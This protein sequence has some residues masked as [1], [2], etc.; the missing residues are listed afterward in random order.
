MSKFLNPTFYFNLYNEQISGQINELPFAIKQ[1]TFQGIFINKMKL[2]NS[3]GID[4]GAW[5]TSKSIV[6]T[7]IR[8]PYGRISAAVQKKLMDN[9]LQV[10]FSVNDIFRWNR[11]VATSQFQNIDIFLDNRWETLK[12]RL[13]FNYKFSQGS[14]KN[15]KSRASGIETEQSRVKLED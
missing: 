15:K 10:R 1:G 2:P 13:S 7:F 3:W 12:F 6:S 9:K 8:E 14:V 4:V 5:Y 11:F